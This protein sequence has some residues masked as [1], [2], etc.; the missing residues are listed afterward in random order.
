VWRDPHT[1]KYSLLGTFSAIGSAV[2]PA[3]SSFSVYFVVTDGHG[4]LPV[5]IELVDVD[6][7]R[8]VVFSAEAKFQFANPLQVVEGSFAFDRL[9]IPEPGEYCLKLFIAGELV[10]GRSLHVEMVGS[11]TLQL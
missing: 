1:G 5:R 10:M 3:V 6:E 9:E 11:P 7:E 4:E 8:P 2:F